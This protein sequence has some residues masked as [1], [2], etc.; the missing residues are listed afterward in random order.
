MD[1]L[2]LLN[3]V[4]IYELQS[5]KDCWDRGDVIAIPAKRLTAD[6]WS[7]IIE[8]VYNRPTPLNPYYYIHNVNKQN[9]LPTNA[10]ANSTGSGTD[11][12]P[13]IIHLKITLPN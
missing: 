2:H 12:T 7:N 10:Y 8:D 11:T 4:C 6:S 1:Y 5:N 9:E 3:C 13:G